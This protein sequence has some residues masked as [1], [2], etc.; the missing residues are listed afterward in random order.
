MLRSFLPEIITV[1]EINTRKGRHLVC[2]RKSLH[3]HV[4]S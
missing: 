4:I 3:V 1:A 2:Q